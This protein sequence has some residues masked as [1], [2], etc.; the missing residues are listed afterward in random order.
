MALK[1]YKAVVNGTETTLMLTPE[2]AKARGLSQGAASDQVGF[3]A[4]KKKAPAPA[5]KAVTAPNK[6]GD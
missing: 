3:A 6:S 4:P 5:N 2:D 1:A